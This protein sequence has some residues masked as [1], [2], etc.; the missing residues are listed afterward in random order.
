VDRPT[1]ERDRVGEVVQWDERD[2]LFARRDLFQYFGPGT[3]QFQAYYDAHPEHLEYD[4]KI[5]ALPGLGRAGGPDIAMFGAQ[6]GAVVKIASESAV[7]G[8][9]SPER[10]EFPPARAAQKIKALARL[11]G[12]D[13]VGIG[14]LRQEWVYSHVGRSFG[15]REGFQPWG[16]PVDLDHH[17]HA[18]AMGFR[19]D[20]GLIQGAPDFPALLATAKGYATGAWVS[21]QLAGYIRMLGFSARAHHLYNYRVLAVPVAVDCGLG[22]LSRAGFLLTREFG[23]GLRLGVVTT[24]MPLAHDRPVDS[25][26]QSFCTTCE[27]CAEHCPIGAIPRGN[28][29]EY[30]GIKKWKLDEAKCYRYWHA[31]GTDCALCMAACPWTKPSTWFH[32]SLAWLAT[33]KGP[34]QSWMVQ[35]ERLFNGRRG[36]APRPN[37]LEPA[38]RKKP[39]TRTPG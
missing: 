39:G 12:A 5:D 26:V 22:E 16:T 11:L 28:K 27:L 8:E 21:I 18:I 35:A 23:L 19:M 31:V 1:Y 29:V 4:A 7:D 20:H 17:T 9:P 15:D 36:P 2:V 6:L 33:R 13:L 25:G 10:I 37:F 32:R 3:T 34:H 14:P 24:D 38:E 30:N